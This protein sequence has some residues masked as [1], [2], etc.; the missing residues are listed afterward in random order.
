MIHRERLMLWLDNPGALSEQTGGLVK[1]KS[2]K[3]YVGDSFRLG[4][5]RIFEYPANTP[6]R[7]LIIRYT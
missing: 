5:V 4:S 7:L 3:K 1:R 2:G 6:K